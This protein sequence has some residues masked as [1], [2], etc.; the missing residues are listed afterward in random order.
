MITD[1]KRFQKANVDSASS[2]ETDLRHYFI[3]DHLTNWP[4]DWV[5]IDWAQAHH[6][7]LADVGHAPY[8]EDSASFNAAIEAFFDKVLADCKVS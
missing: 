8:C 2:T 5:K 1:Q 4:D 6:W 3:D 7:L